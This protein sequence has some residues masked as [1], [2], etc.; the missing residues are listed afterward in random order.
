MLGKIA[1]VEE[2]LTTNGHTHTHTHTEII[3][4]QI[5]FNIKNILAQVMQFD[6][7]RQL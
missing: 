2:G 5:L 3:L 1:I 7:P 6:H 4:C